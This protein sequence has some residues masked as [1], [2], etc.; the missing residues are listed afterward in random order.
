MSSYGWH[1]RSSRLPMTRRRRFAAGCGGSPRT[2]FLDFFTE[3]KRR[4]GTGVGDHV[5]EALET[6][7]ARDD[8]MDRLDQEFT[9]ALVSQACAVV[10]ARVEPQTWEAFVATAYDGLPGEDVAARL[11]MTVTAVFKAKSR[12]LGFIR[13]EI[14]R[15]EGKS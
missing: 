10:R 13:Q 4:P 3:R 14:Q 6:R 1:A 11:G 7:Q 15:L 9:R 8:L 2:R 5:L 12:V